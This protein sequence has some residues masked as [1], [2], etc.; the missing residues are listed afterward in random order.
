MLIYVPATSSSNFQ[1]LANIDNYC[2]FYLADPTTRI[3]QNYKPNFGLSSYK[4]TNNT[5]QLNMA[6]N[7][8]ESIQIVML[9]I[10]QQHMSIYDISF[11]GFANE[12]HPNQ[13]SITANQTTF[14]S[15]IVGYVDP[16][17]NIVPDILYDFNAIAVSNGKNLPLWFTFYVPKDTKVGKYNGTLRFEVTSRRT[18]DGGVYSSQFINFNILLNVFNFTLPEIP[19]LKSCFGFSKSYPDFNI[20]MQWYR[21]HRMM[22]WSSFQLPN[23]TL[24]F[25]WNSQ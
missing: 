15:Y 9:P 18:T 8:Y 23:C 13:I 17:G 10:N 3:N 16:L 4:N 1:I 25:G 14:K 21:E 6:K 24:K 20:V 19:T 12:T 5:I 22:H 7:E 2:L 11:S